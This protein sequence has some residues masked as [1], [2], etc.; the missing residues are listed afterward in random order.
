MLI[1]SC[2]CELTSTV[3][4]IFIQHVPYPTG[5]GKATNSIGTVLFT[6]SIRSATLIDI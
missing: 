2:Y 1:E 4:S 3:E 5:A 6:T